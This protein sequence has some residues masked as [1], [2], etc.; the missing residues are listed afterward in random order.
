M[1]LLVGWIECRGLTIVEIGDGFQNTA[2]CVQ[3]L[4]PT[5]PAG[6]PA[7]EQ[8]NLGVIERPKGGAL[9][10]RL[11]EGRYDGHIVVTFVVKSDEWIG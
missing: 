4:W 10:Q 3:P 5:D 8:D 1:R 11:T 7:R 6:V 2:V 9:A